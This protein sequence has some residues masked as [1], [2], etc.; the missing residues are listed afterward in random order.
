MRITFVYKLILSILLIVTCQFD[1]LAQFEE[2]RA[3]PPISSKLIG[4]SIA[5]DSSRTSEY[6]NMGEDSYKLKNVISFYIREV[7]GAGTYFA[8]SFTA[9]V[10]F[11]LELTVNGVPASPVSDTLTINYDTTT[12]SKYN[13]RAYILLPEQAEKAKITVTGLSITGA[14]GWNPISV[15]QLDNDIRVL[16]YY[17]A[18]GGSVLTADSLSGMPSNPGN[19]ELSDELNV[20]WMWAHEKYNMSQLEW[21]FIDSNMIDNYTYD[22]NNA[23]N[24]FQNNS[25]RVD[26]DFGKENYK[27]PLLYPAG[28]LFYRVRPALRRNMGNVITGAWSSAK[29]FVIKGHQDSLNWQSSTSF[30]ENGKYKTVI[31]YFDGSLR[32]RQTVTK[33]NSTGNT[34]VAETIY[35]LQGRPNIQILPT[36]TIDQTIKYFRDFNHFAGQQIEGAGDLSHYDDPAKYF[37]LSIAAVSCNTPPP[38]DTTSGN[39]RYYSGSNDWLTGVN[40]EEKS[41]FIPNAQGYAYTE[42]RFM[43]DA[44]ERVRS[45]GGVGI[46]HQIGSGHETRYWYGKPS[47]P[48]MDALFGT[49]VGDASHYSKNMVED[50]NQQV[51]V[52]YVDMH[53]RTVAT[54]LAGD[55]TSGIQSIFNTSDY[56]QANGQITDSLVTPVTNIIKDKSIESISTILVAAP[57]TKYDFVYELSPAILSQFDCNNQE[58]CFDCKYDLEISI[59]SEN[60]GDT[61]PKIRRYNNLKLV[62]ANLAC[63]SSMGFTGDGFTELK[64]LVFSDTLNIGS[65]IIRKTLT[66]NDS[67]FQVRRDIALKAFLCT[68]EQHIYDSVYSVL[69]GTTGC[70]I[71]AASVCDSCIAQLGSLASYKSKY[72]VSI[73]LSP[74]DTSLNSE[75]QNYYTQDSLECASVCGGLNTAAKT[76]Q[77]IRTQMLNDMIP[78]TGQY[79]IPEDS[80]KYP[81]GT[82]VPDYTRAEAK[83]NIFTNHYITNGSSTPKTLFYRNPLTESGKAFYLTDDNLV[84]SSIHGHDEINQVILDTI[85]PNAFADLF[86]SSWTNSLIKYHPEY[87]KL[88]FAET[89]LKSSYDWLDKVQSCET[90][91]AASSAGYINPTNNSSIVP[92]PTSGGDPFFAIAGNS[93]LKAK[94][95]SII[96]NAFSAGGPSIWQIANSTV[97]CA[98]KDSLEKP[99][100]IMAQD[101]TGIDPSITDPVQ[102]NKV[103]EQFR[104]IY[105]AKRND[106]V[107]SYINL[108]PNVLGTLEMDSLVS[109][110]KQLTFASLQQI[111]KQ[112]NLTAWAS[113]MNGDTAAI[114]QSLVAS[115]TA[116]NC[117]AQRP[118]WKAKLLQCEV[119]VSL[120]NTDSITVNTIIENILDSMVLVCH[121]S[122]NAQQL[123]GASNVNPA[124]NGAPKNFEQVINGVL[125]SHGIDTTGANGYFCNPYTIDFP[126]P[127]G[128]NPPLWVNNTNVIDTCGCKRFSELKTEAKTMGYDTLNL[129]GTLGMNQF[130]K[131]NYQDSLTNILWDGLQRCNL[132]LFKDTCFFTPGVDSS[133]IPPCFTCPADTS[134]C[135][136][137]V[138]YGA[139][140]INNTSTNNVKVNFKTSSGTFNCKIIATNIATSVITYFTIDSCGSNTDTISLP[141][142]ERY[143]IQISVGSI[144]GLCYDTSVVHI[145]SASTNDCKT[146]YNPIY[147]PEVVVIPPFLSCGYQKPCIT[148]AKLD[149]LTSEFKIKFPSLTGVPYSVADSLSIDQANQNELWSRFLNYRTGFSKNALEYL[150][151]YEACKGDSTCGVNAGVSNLTLTARA[152]PYPSQYVARTSIT[153]EGGFE[154]STGDNYL[155]YI[156]PA[157][158]T[159]TLSSNAMAICASVTP[160]NAQTR[161][162]T[163]DTMPCKYVQTQS[164][165]IAKM[166]FEKRKDSLIANF[167]SLYMAKCLS[168]KYQEK[169]YVKY[170]PKE[171]HYTLYY[172]DQ[173]G[174]LV[175]T[176]PPSGVRP[177]FRPTFLD[178]VITHRNSGADLKNYANNEYL[179]TNYRYNTLNQVVSQK[180]PDAGIS[181]F[182]YD[183]LGRLVVSQNAKQQAADLYSYTLYDE[184]G[185]ITEVGEKPQTVAMHPDTSRNPIALQEW[186]DGTGTK[187]QITR[188]IYDE[189]YTPISSTVNGISG[190]YQKN[191]RNRVSYTYVKNLDSQLTD[192]DAATFYTYDIHG[193]VDTLLQDYQ[194]GIGS[195]SCSADTSR[196]GNRYKKMVYGY[197]LISGKVNDVAYQ[198]NQPDQFYHRYNYDSENRLTKVETSKDKIYWE[199]D[200]VYDYYRHGPLARTILGQNQVQGLDYAYTIQGW[201]KGVNT[202]ASLTTATGTSYDMGQDGVGSSANSLVAR[203]A[204]GFSLNYFYGDYHAIG[205]ARPFATLPASLPAG[206][207]AIITGSQLFNGNIAAMAVNIPQL[208]DAKVYGYKYDQLN[209]IVRMDAFNDLNNATN[210]FTPTYLDDYHEEVTYDPN[211]N[212]KSYL[213]NGTTAGGSP[214]AMDKLTYQY[215]KLANG[216]V[217]S[218][219]LRYVH[220]Q[221]TATN[222]TEDIDSQKP[223]TFTLTD[224][225]N[226]KDQSQSTD[227]YRYDAIGNLIEDKAEGITDIQWTVY[228]KISNISKTLNSVTS[229]IAYT[230]DVSG[231]RISKVVTT[232]GIDKA[233]YYVRDA[234]G[235]VMSIYEH[236]SNSSNNTTTSA[237]AQTELHL[238]GSNRLGVYNVNVGVENC[239]AITDPITIFTR[240]NKFFELG[241]HLGNVLVTVSDRKLQ[242]TTNGTTVD[243]YTA[244]VITANDYYPGGMLTPRRTYQATPTS[245]YRF[246]INGQ[247][248]ES[249]LSEN[250]TTAKYWEYDS[251]I[252][253][254]WNVDPKTDVSISPYNC[255]GGNPI[256]F[257]DPFGDT[258]IH[259]QKMEGGNAK[260]AT[261]LTEVVIKSSSRSQI[262]ERFAVAFTAI[263]TNKEAIRSVSNLLEGTG[264]R[265]ANAE[266]SAFRFLGPA[267]AV[268]TL[269]TLSGDNVTPYD[270]RKWAEQYINQALKDGD[271][272]KAKQEI[273][274]WN[275]DKRN[276]D[277]R[278]VLRYMS[279]GEYNARIKPDMG[280]PVAPPLSPTFKLAVKWITPDI[281]ISSSSAKTFLAL[282]T[283][284]D[285]AIWTFEA[286]IMATKMPSGPGAY[287]PVKPNNAEPGGG[288]EATI[289]QPFPIH[290]WFPLIK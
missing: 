230:Y 277:N 119:L 223:G 6:T 163:I 123:F 3:L 83:Y 92:Y 265:L 71:P 142:N 76:L 145:L 170:T 80:I 60:C 15:L 217:T 155:I 51:S 91:A 270:R 255:F 271:P 282:P 289:V 224:V 209:R 7:D 35:D 158:D 95:D 177:N 266:L 208:G 200:A 235:N 115:D 180:T 148:C 19:P 4:T 141:L 249:D 2:G 125:S 173:A 222:Y 207:N 50:A 156:D 192:W 13:V 43:D 214:L 187:K 215:E 139:F 274:R 89:Y 102:K 45:Q 219:K 275:D 195:I 143:N 34:V 151:A 212:I 20:S 261:T 111:A 162:Y 55:S 87:S 153:I 42:T 175:K 285:I 97:L 88:V 263:V 228:G 191:L 283:A 120:L 221:V 161:I 168:A 33:D 86:Q 17:D 130:L 126:K 232:G 179:A 152:S 69:L 225:E 166:L 264:V 16:Q 28:N 57:N 239:S 85:T 182:W 260:S 262:K 110:G 197:D 52:S 134:A 100:C 53:G 154:S 70:G 46:D 78:F 247:D 211:G 131:L 281:Y 82:T 149:S 280:L 204:F 205:T 24:L 47:Q 278:I 107:L 75:I 216:Q 37:D 240:G 29:M 32:S 284:P 186:V 160:I 267:A 229:N 124:Y 227:N 81:S 206:S 202:T 210:V 243:Y 66:V 167:V 133:A 104:S 183:K 252:V 5:P 9:T 8:S 44:T 105:L 234:S 41:N 164:E 72:L 106:F 18:L 165:F 174:N 112:N 248:K 103:W 118:F 30:A 40:A 25:T 65:Y 231:N 250:I 176:L 101:S 31:Q 159:C 254:R 108:Q 129:S 199:Q 136:T 246:S 150:A 48:E 117:N 226:D 241:N 74:T 12:G 113:A 21:A 253:R 67:M 128:K 190:L 201:L 251:R 54:A 185:R 188:T 233:T 236:S 58:I 146:L 27:V 272:L 39:G 38:L 62:P 64:Q 290:G 84:D 276:K 258:T 171:Y 189:V 196:R 59:K 61:T 269:V 1:L 56:P 194:T 193:N 73:G 286:E 79:A 237:L 198:P 184:L 122:V 96:I 22:L 157:L 287:Q 238:Y 99:T 220:D 178:S 121:N 147:L 256:S 257:S 23:D 138:L 109:Q 244:D 140:Y 273:E 127:Y 132:G 49:E 63:D 10:I 94:M 93:A 213:R 259:G 203:D 11:N 279:L 114:R 268:A 98:T 90:Y 26:I 172:Y 181:N 144:H 137:P 36:P 135:G 77:S 14:S 169:F 245:K 242:H 218:N 116:D 288:R 68:T